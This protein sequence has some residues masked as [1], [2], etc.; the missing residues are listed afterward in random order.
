MKSYHLLP[1]KIKHLSTLFSEN[2][3][4]ICKDSIIVSKNLTQIH[5]CFFKLTRIT[6]IEQLSKADQSLGYIK[7][8]SEF[9]VCDPTITLSIILLFGSKQTIPSIT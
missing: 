6:S 4:V 2:Q 9:E 7:A 3:T 1:S 5:L 8:G